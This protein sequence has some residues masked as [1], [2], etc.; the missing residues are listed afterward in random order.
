LVAVAEV[1]VAGPIP[2]V[3]VGVLPIAAR[4]AA[5]HVRA[6][7]AMSTTRLTI[8]RVRNFLLDPMDLQAA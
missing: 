3:R 1:A 7:P 8:R 6:D 2:H 4:A 5:G